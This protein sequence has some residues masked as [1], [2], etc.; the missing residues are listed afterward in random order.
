MA[1]HSDHRAKPAPQQRWGSAAGLDPVVAGP[2]NQTVPPSLRAKYPP[3]KAPS[4]PAN[5]ARVVAAPAAHVRTGYN[6]ATS[7][8]VP[9]KRQA[10]QRTYDNADG[11]QT[12]EFSASALNYRDRDGTWAPIDSTLVP[13]G[14]AAGGWVRTADS[15]GLRLAARSD[16][17]EL[18]R[19]TLPG[20]GVLGYGLADAAPVTGTVAGDTARY[21]GVWP[22]VDVELQAQP[23]GV[24]ETLVLSSAGARRTFVFPLKLTGL[25]AALDGN[26]VV[27][28]DTVGVRRA[29]IPAGYLQDAHGATSDAMTYRIVTHNGAPALE[30]RL[31]AGWL[32]EADRA[33][34]VRA[35]PPVVANGAATQSLV[36]Q[37]NGSHGGGDELLVGSK[38]GVSSAS[39]LK[40]PG[41]ADD[42]RFHTIYGAQL[43]VVN[44]ESASCRPR[45]VSVHPVTGS[46]SSGD[47]DTRYPGPSV[48]AA[49]VT[50]S[51]AQ[52]YV[53]LGQSASS[54]PV[55][56]SV[57]DLGTKGRDLIQGW[58]NGQVNN[59]LSLRAPVG[60][61][62]AWKKFAGTGTANPPRLYVTHSP[63]N[64]KYSVPNP[65]P[66]PA[67]L[68]NQAGKVK[69][70]I[71]NKSAA[72]WTPSTY[73]FVYRAYNA[74][75]K[76]SVGQ[77]VA[78]TLPSTVARGASVTLDA[79]IRA[80][81]IGQYWLDFSMAKINGPV[82]TDELVQPARIAL[83]IKNILPTVGEIFPPN[84]YPSPTLTPQLWAQATDLDAPPKTTLQYKFEYCGVTDAG[85]PT[86]C[87]Q[88]AYQ[89]KQAF[90]VPAGKLSW[91]KTYQWR[92][93]IKDNADEVITPYLTL[94]TAIPQPEITSRIA[95]APY[96]SSDRDFDPN[97]GNYTTG[98]VDASVNNVG[99]PLKI[100][101]TY[102]SLDP[103]QDLIFGAGWMT[104]Y[105]MRVTLDDDGSGNAVVTY[106]DGQQVRFGRNPDGTFA[107]PA[108]R[109]AAFTINSSRGV[110]VLK[111]GSGN[112]YEF[113]GGGG[114]IFTISDKWSRALAFT[115]DSQTGKLAKVQSLTSLNGRVGRSLRFGWTGAKVTS[116]STDPVDGRTLTWTYAYTGDQ[117]STV[118]APAATACTRY[119]YAEGSHYRSGVLDT[120]PDSYWR[121]GDPAA[122]A[123]AG[124]EIAN[125][126]GKDAGVVK[127]VTTGVAGALAGTG[128][129]A[130]TFNGTTSV[131]ELPRGVVKRTRDS[132]V[133]LWFRVTGSQTGGPLLGYQDKALD[134]TPTVGV[135]L[136]YVGTDGHLR[137][138]FRTTAAA[139][140]P[141][142]VIQE[143]RDGVWHH[144]VLSVSADVQTLYL[145]GEKRV[146]KPVTEG[147][148]DHS[149]LTYNQV[150]AAY[151]TTPASWSGWGT[152]ARRS[153]GGSIDEVAIYGRALSAQAVATHHTLGLTAVGQLA[154]VTL[155]SGKISS[156]TGYDTDLDRVKEYTD[157][158]G[159]TWKIGSPLVY[160]G[161]TDLRRSV[162]VLDP[163]DRPYL[164]EYDAL[165]G[166][167]LRSGSPLGISTRPED[168]PPTPTPS[169]SPTEVCSTPDPGD[170]RFC[171]TIPG[172]AGG[173][174]FTEHEL[175]GM[176]I[177]SFFYNDKGQQNRI[178]N[179]NGA[180]V[181]MTFDDRGN[182]TSRK[183]CRESTSCQTSYTAYTTPNTANPLDPRNDLPTE[184]RDARSASATDITYR[185]S[186]A[187]N[188]V[189]DVIT[190]TGADS[191]PTTTTYTSGTELAVGSTTETVASGLISSV[192]DS[193]QRTTRYSYNVYGDLAVVVSP[194]GLR[195]EYTYDALGRRIQDKEISDTY[196]A[197]LV[198]TY[199]YDD[200]NRPVGTTGPE[201]TNEIDNV[202]HQPV[203][204]TTYDV[205]GNA[206]RVEV[207]DAKD[208]NEPPRV[209]TTEYD[210]FNRVSRTVNAEGAE[211]TEDWDRFGN[212][213]SVV[214]GNGN[215][216]EYAY[217]A[218]NKLAEVR[219]YDWHGDPADGGAPQDP[220]ADYTVLN[221]Y[222]YDFA[223]R[224]AAQLDSM[225]RRLEYTYY[226]DDL[227]DK[228]VLKGLHNPDGT[229]RDYAVEDNTY[230]AAG[231][232]TRKVTSNGLRTTGNTIDRMGRTQAAVVDPGGTNRTSTFTYDS[233]GN[234]KSTVQTGNAS[235]VPFLT[236]AGRTNT[237]QNVYDEFGR[238]KQEK[239]V[240]G[241]DSRITSYAYDRRGNVL[242]ETDPRGNVAGADAA[243][244]TTTY[245]YDEAGNMVTSVAP[246]VDVESDGGPAQSAQPTVL[247]G[248]NA[249]GEAVATRDALGNVNRTSFDRLGRP[250]Q[251]TGPLYTPVSGPATG[252][253]PITRT[254]YDALN[255]PVETTDA[256][257]FVTRYIYDRL[258]R[259]VTRDQ[260]ASTN[261]ERAVWRY[262]YTRTGKTLSTTSPTGIRTE[263]T[264]DDLDRPV[265][266]TK[267][268]RRPVADTFTTTLKYDDAGGIVETKAPS[269]AT[270]VMR[271]NTA[272]D[273][274]STSD[275]AGVTTRQG[276]DGFGNPIAV[277]DGADR[278]IRTN[279][280][281]FGQVTSKIDMN[282]DFSV[283]RHEDF[284]Y[285][286][287]G[288]VT[289]R[290]SA[291]N[292]KVTFSY[293]AL[294]RLT[295]Q[296]EPKSATA[297]ITT[298]FGYDANG[299]RTRYTDG[300]QN[301]TYFDVNSLGLPEKVIEP[302]TAAHP[303]LG[304]RTW[305]V[306]YDL[307]GNPTQ[308]TVPGGVIRSREY[309]AANRL[310]AETG[311]GAP[312]TNRGLAY[313]LE[314]RV[315]GVTA[316]GGSNT[317]GYDDRSDLLTATGPSG[318]AGYTYNDDGQVTGRTDAAG[319]AAF[320]YQRGRLATVK[321]GA[322]A[323]TQTLGYNVA[324]QLAT[325]DYGAGRVRSYG[326]DE[327]GRTASDVLKNSAN[328]EITKTVY[329][330][331]ADDH[332]TGKDTSGT[333]VAGT[334]SYGY[335]DAG[336]LTTWTSSTGTVD[337]AWDDSG[338][339]TRAGPKTATYDERNRLLTD[340]DYKYAYTPRGT[341]ASRTSSG[342][343]EPYSFDAFDRLLGA[344]GQSYSYDGLNRMVSRNGTAFAY[345]GF[346]QDP[347]NDGTE[348][349]ARGAAGELLAVVDGPEKRL[350]VSDEHDDVVG[351]FDA[352]APLT[353]LRGSST[354]D[355]YGQQ[356]AKIGEQ[357]N[358]GFQGDWTDPATGQVDMGA[359]WYE[360]GTGGFTSRDSVNYSQGDSILANR[361]TYGAGDPMS[362][363]DPTG[364]W[365]SCGW[366]K[367][368][369]GYV[370]SAWHATTS[371]VSTGW[372]YVS[373]GASWLW[374]QAKAA[375]SALVRFG[376][377]TVKAAWHGLQA[378][379]RAINSVYNKYVAPTVRNA[380]DYAKQRAQEIHRAAVAV[381][382]K[383]RAAVAY[384]AKNTPI[385]RIASAALPVIAGLGKLAMTAITKPAALTASFSAVVQ[386]F[387]KAADQLYQEATAVKDAVVGGLKTTGDWIV[388][389]K[390]GIAGFVAG[391]VVGL[392]CGIAIGWTGVGAIGCAALAGAAGSIVSDMVEGGKGWKE[393]GANALM[394]A[395]IG[396]VLGPLS[397]IGGSAVG[398]GVRGLVSG[399]LREAASM[400]SAAAVNT[401]R[402]FGSTQVGGLLGRAL[403]NRTAGSAAREAAGATCTSNSFAPGT[404]VVMADGSTKAIE[405]VEVGDRVLAT[406]P[407]TGKT[408]PKK[409]TEL[410]V[411]YGEK[412]MVELTV[413]VDGNK[414]TKAA[415][416]VATSG[417][418]F[419]VPDLNRWVKAGDLKPGSML[420][421]A[422]GTY[423]QISAVRKWTA[424][425]QRVNN[426]TIDGLHTYYVFA[427]DTPVL[428]HNCGTASPH[429]LLRTESLEGPY[430]R[431]RVAEI[432]AS[433]R[434]NGWVGNGIDVFEMNSQK[435]VLNGHHRVAA[436]KQAGIDVKYR[437]VPESE[438]GN[439]DYRDASEV[440]SAA[441][442]V[443]PDR[444]V[445]RRGRRGR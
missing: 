214:D 289:S 402:S 177:R 280:D 95:N 164:Y 191:V 70:T 410:V 170:P 143:V 258:N 251:S 427:G 40:F 194:N 88:T 22:G 153:F 49:L 217:T 7:R 337:Y 210:E 109:N 356:I 81:P 361:Y 92:A 253:S 155:P 315:T 292:K 105:D 135:P 119:S 363:N 128:N 185:S 366:C 440:V 316:P 425:G 311:S 334:N 58:A 73:N 284:G 156:E 431:Q 138:Q 320:G 358:V 45:A 352:T 367:K 108:G 252:A 351:S 195:N 111:D 6:A 288:N 278:I 230:D 178:V 201:N 238:L 180:E 305:T 339:R 150:G 293:D 46:W 16:A 209:T 268:E 275:P 424:Q 203:S 42:L 328:T 283:L 319:T 145:D 36:V 29:T 310:T 415:S 148:L 193:E 404:A 417:H 192:K 94:L 375:G 349:F 332:L 121:L 54:C 84:G 188:S 418:P 388:E 333:A 206:I 104:Q 112:T 264:Y 267:F 379:G 65:V 420:Q 57:F 412:K 74:Q 372:N 115:Y 50:K 277:V 44:F 134:A 205:D 200:A 347:V 33:F 423:V 408:K 243:A 244:Y 154:M 160:G 291:L 441:V 53:A 414:E 189:G 27:L 157:G 159:G 401:A 300:R 324:G 318:N 343:V 247:T 10:R 106:P 126:L 357:S 297:S 411:G 173:P 68:Q 196:P 279:Y 250:V 430:S 103:R 303:Q 326:Y 34:P 392:G 56:G 439:H 381:R 69:F 444:I 369:A 270:T 39:Y 239:V 142:E 166:R 383:T 432:S 285:D 266:S 176:V 298:S 1:V 127:N 190:E 223:G 228:V 208:P 14:D 60:D 184:V 28:T 255:N 281:G 329:R 75:T 365:P 151:A 282:P 26:Q 32:T 4:L 64:A 382:D 245:R 219:L 399:G 385:G 123:A 99:P 350:T 224:M 338:N 434:E 409:V 197:G 179:E 407:T 101:R 55:T 220:D 229:V 171:T 8:E 186:T 294:N 246:K 130:A 309:D 167:L 231:N 122:S 233:L 77:F 62:S 21:A 140:K 335:D 144:V 313:D 398:A 419:W 37:E 378:A 41:L 235:N 234:V 260:P 116:V 59:G 100:T 17:A 273:L 9:A 312:T 38:D 218:T 394:G 152:T 215:H 330:Y 24:K 380:V 355:P 248:Y 341:L 137:G 174:V 254:M 131:V 336:R 359:R 86:G 395:T 78:A 97:I 63:Y 169:P 307:N 161:N 271:Y 261:S 249:F 445:D 242:T 12:T 207:K 20:G 212:R 102:N 83:E 124:S 301:V 11:T 322:T 302:V 96:G 241:A 370:S 181:T 433:M 295:R 199:T 13:A 376:V 43:Q 211:Q 76:V 87:T 436:A 374:N 216:Y 262:T 362:N 3:I 107:A 421:T 442:E 120:G 325:V 428:V 15:V 221:S 368:A 263:M 406:D 265:T 113:T 114:K 183:T 31:D 198:T 340:S 141:M 158:N 327:L 202:R 345:A 93:F 149:L 72:D 272:G 331:D 227:L 269:G 438:L 168:R 117:L 287:A 389:H 91:S 344:E 51:F 236:E 71:T 162:Q 187:Y 48:G 175:T 237:V 132:A 204:T 353:A 222:A 66:N 136:L 240:D 429:D 226:A 147:V 371:A 213:V 257:G 232:L 259:V 314:S 391:T 308:L 30:L 317:Y 397:S 400:G 172:N 321:D 360:P 286:E 390:A 19:T 387:N 90:T 405:D 304:D 299:N 165:A 182:V 426:L 323:V 290:T 89:S 18:V 110:Y 61:N 393:M 47:T 354:F 306:T 82:F 133:E 443:G 342:L 416:I 396:A 25:T 80:L 348:L 377:N 163:A 23:G 225:G 276:Y 118:C 373:S 435:Y 296:V 98:A 422:A 413:D 67:V 139:P 386:D 364:H 125:N 146:S 129:T 346:E 52:G 2:R 274:V 5:S 85:A 79:T 35:D 437:L 403:G 384:V 256:R